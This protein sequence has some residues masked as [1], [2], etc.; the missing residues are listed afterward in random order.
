VKHMY[1]AIFSNI[2]KHEITK[3]TEKSAEKSV[4]HKTRS[5]KELRELKTTSYYK[6]FNTFDEAKEHLTIKQRIKIDGL[7]YVLES[8]EKE[9]ITISNITEKD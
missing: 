9:L 3:E 4:W 6:W 7:K 2:E 8:A 5:G 1:R